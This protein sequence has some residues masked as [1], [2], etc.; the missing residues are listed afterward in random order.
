MDAFVTTKTNFERLSHFVQSTKGLVSK[1]AL[2]DNGPFSRSRPIL[3]LLPPFLFSYFVWGGGGGG[4]GRLA[5]PSE[6]TSPELKQSVVGDFHISEDSATILA[7]Y[8]RAPDVR[9]SGDV[10][11]ARWRWKSTTDMT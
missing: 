2:D 1:R 9:M 6:I 7:R 3:L 8:Y 4:G 10:M 11:T 5:P